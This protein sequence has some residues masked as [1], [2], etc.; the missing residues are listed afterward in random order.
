M[1]RILWAFSI[2]VFWRALCPCRNFLYRIGRVFCD[3]ELGPPIIKTALP[4][5][6]SYTATRAE[7]TADFNAAGVRRIGQPDAAGDDPKRRQRQAKPGKATRRQD[8]KR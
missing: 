4:H 8:L 6:R 3:I 2:S 1:E 5:E 7:A